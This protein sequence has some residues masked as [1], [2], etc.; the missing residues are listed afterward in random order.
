MYNKKQRILFERKN[1]RQN[2]Q[3]CP[4]GSTFITFHFTPNKF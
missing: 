4:L 1:Y 2:D 3:P